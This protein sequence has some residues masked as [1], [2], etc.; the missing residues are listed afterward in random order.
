MLR[1]YRH[2]SVGIAIRAIKLP[3]LWGWRHCST[4]AGYSSNVFV[5]S[6]NELDCG[7]RPR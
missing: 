4:I 5:E 2:V 3:L 7:S 6:R 1:G